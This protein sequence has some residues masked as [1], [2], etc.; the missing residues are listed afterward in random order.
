MTKKYSMV[1]SKLGHVAP[2]SLFAKEGKSSREVGSCGFIV[3]PH[4]MCACLQD[5]K[6]ISVVF[7]YLVPSSHNCHNL[8]S[9]PPSLPLSPLSQKTRSVSRMTSAAEAAGTKAAARFCAQSRG[10]Y[11]CPHSE[12]QEA[13]H[14]RRLHRYGPSRSL[15]RRPSQHSFTNKEVD[16][17]S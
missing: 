8:S 1:E 9:L 2:R 16:Y 12:L 6:P 10:R 14:C 5:V 3:W 15:A 4:E 11:T 7:Y 13:R 17:I